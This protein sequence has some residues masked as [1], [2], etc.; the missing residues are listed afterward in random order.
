MRGDEH[1]RQYVPVDVAACWCARRTRIFSSSSGN[2][3]LVTQMG[4]PRAPGQNGSRQRSARD[5]TDGAFA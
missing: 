5:A 1:E 3:P 4:V 2:G